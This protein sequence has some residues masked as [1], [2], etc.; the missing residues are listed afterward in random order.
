MDVSLCVARPLPVAGI[1][2]LV[3]VAVFV[4]VL[5][6][7]PDAALPVGLGVWLG[8]WLAAGSAHGGSSFFTGSA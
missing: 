4:I 2:V 7:A 1:R 5:R 3:V 6:W 8:S